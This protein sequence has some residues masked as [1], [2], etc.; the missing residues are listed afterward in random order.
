MEIICNLVKNLVYFMF[1]VNIA[2]KLMIDS[3]MQ[4][5]IRLYVGLLLCIMLVDGVKEFATGEK[6]KWSSESL[7]NDSDMEEM[8]E[9]EEEFRQQEERIQGEIEKK[10][11]EKTQNQKEEEKK[12][13][14]D[15]IMVQINE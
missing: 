11:K 8:G 12:I 15:P 3:K 9:I 13:K 2:E 4:K 6:I 10:Y 1:F 5:Y 14:I 7:V